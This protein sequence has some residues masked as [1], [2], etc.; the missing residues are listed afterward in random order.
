MPIP[1]PT[2]AAVSDAITHYR[3][4][5]ELTCDE[6][7]YVLG[8][9]G[10]PLTAGDIVAIE[11]RKRTATVDDLIAIAFALDTTP[12]VLLTHIPI[13]MPFPEGP[14]ATGLPADVDQAEVRAWIESRT[15]LDP[16]SRIAWCEDRISRLRIRAAHFE[17]QL[18]GAYAE[19]R[20]LGILVEREADALPVV[21]LNDRTHD[22]EYALNQTELAL[23]M[24][25]TRLDQLREA[26]L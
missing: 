14:I 20:E 13:D 2:A 4:L 25:E 3:Q 18:Q 6:L 17:E 5:A 16:Q 21:R 24:A 26:T 1:T 23:A 7:S 12:A 9:N 22:G 11:S 19:A 8:V 15:G 10:Y